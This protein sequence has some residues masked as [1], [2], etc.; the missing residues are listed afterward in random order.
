MTAKTKLIV[1][2]MLVVAF[3]VIFFVLGLRQ[4]QNVAFIIALTALALSGFNFYFSL[5]R[6][7]YLLRPMLCFE[8]NVQ[9]SPPT[10]NEQKSGIQSSWFLRLKIINRGLTPA[11]KC[12]G[13]LI[14]VR[15][16]NGKRLDRFDPF[17]LY[18]GRQNQLN[19]YCPID[20]QGNG[21]FCFLDV[22]QVTEAD[23]NN[24]IDLRIVDAGGRLVLDSNVGEGKKL[25]P[26][27][28]HLCIAVYSEEDVFI[29]PTWFTVSCAA[30][31]SAQKPPII[32]TKR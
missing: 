17:N 4:A 11:R 18:W 25:P 9:H 10:P 3:I 22:A 15:D 2:D 27:T 16:N 7:K 24:P 32:D 21:D 30:D 14:E 28:Y 20:I 19:P 13:R 26:G 6:P 5:Y 1:F 23:K 8:C 12:V 29:E 31:F